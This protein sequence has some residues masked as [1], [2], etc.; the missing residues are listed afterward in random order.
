MTKIAMSDQEADLAHY[1]LGSSR[2]AMYAR[3]NEPAWIA[4]EPFYLNG[5]GY[6]VGSTFTKLGGHRK[7][8][9]FELMD[10]HWIEYAG[11]IDN[12]LLFKSD[13]VDLDGWY[14]AFYQVGDQLLIVSDSGAH[15][16][17]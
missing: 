13:G 14:Y 2:G 16:V 1:E 10:G 8:T 17:W 9:A 12:L 6:K 4:N 5:H 11:R 15:D 7:A 3:A